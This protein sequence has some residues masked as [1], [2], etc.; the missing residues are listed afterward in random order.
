MPG[1]GHCRTICT[2]RKA[3]TFH[4]YDHLT[5]GARL[6]M[7]WTNVPARSRRRYESCVE[8]KG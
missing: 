2:S 1:A 6:W 7:N 4:G 3:A 5:G 8:S